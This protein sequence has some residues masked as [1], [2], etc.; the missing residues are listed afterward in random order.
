MVLAPNLTLSTVQSH[1]LWQFGVMTE[2]ADWLEMFVADQQSPTAL[3]DWVSTTVD[4]IIAGVDLPADIRPVLVAAVEEHWLA[5]LGGVTVD[6]DG[7]TELVPAAG[8][9]SIQIARHH[10]GLPVLLKVYQSAQEASWDFAVDVV[11]H[12]PQDL[13]HESL[14]VWFWTKANRWFATSVELSVALYQDEVER[15]R[16]RG[17]ARRY[18]LVADVLDGKSVGSTELSAELGGHPIAGVT[19]VAVIAHAMDADSIERLEP[20]LVRLASSIP[21][22][23]LAVVRPGGRELWGWLALN[24]APST[25]AQ[26]DSRGVD[27]AQIRF[28]IGEAAEGIEGFVRSHRDAR[29]AQRVALSPRRKIALTVYED[30][31]ALTLLTGDPDAAARFARAVLRG[32]AGPE[33][34]ELR[35][36]VRY[37]LTTADSADQVATS[38]G[39]H[40]NTVR[41]RIQQAERLLGH[42]IRERAGDLVLALDYFDAF[43]G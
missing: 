7:A 24:V 32:L 27:P 43:L 16:R 38:L 39:I 22:A 26:W 41:Y 30:V 10:L 29:A 4:A 8:D 18:E 20:S 1:S 37:V 34:D 9:L 19:Q 25:A 2:I 15:I 14:L 31:A 40:K 5:F 33:L 17:D 6:A 42:P 36:T 13:D 35:G 11:G 28:A 21:G 3:D 23:R 12:A